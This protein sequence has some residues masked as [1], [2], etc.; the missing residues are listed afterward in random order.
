HHDLVRTMTD[1]A[2]NHLPGAAVEHTGGIMSF[3]NEVRPQHYATFHDALER[4][5]GKQPWSLGTRTDLTN[6]EATCSGARIPPCS[7]DR[8]VAENAQP[9]TGTSP[10]SPDASSHRS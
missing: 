10:T 8:C 7:A 6:T 4:V 3:G 2:G 5:T 1:S 9:R